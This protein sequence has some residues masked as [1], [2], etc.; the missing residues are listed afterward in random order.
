M[1]ANILQWSLKEI[2]DGVEHQLNIHLDGNTPLQAIEKIAMQMIAHCAKVKEAQAQQ[3][4]AQKVAEEANKPQE[5]T[6]MPK[7]DLLHPT[8]VEMPI[9][10]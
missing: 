3:M 2:V 9:P 10:E 6:E 5:E 7:E 1:F 4:A 8:G